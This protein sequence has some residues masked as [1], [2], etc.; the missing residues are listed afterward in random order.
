MIF[1]VL[2]NSD[3]KAE[4]FLPGFFPYYYGLV[5]NTLMPFNHHQSHRKQRTDK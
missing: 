5:E 1:L 4:Q 2:F 3:K